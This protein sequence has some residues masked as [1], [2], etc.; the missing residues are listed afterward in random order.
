MQDG[1]GNASGK[2][3]FAEVMLI[4]YLCKAETFNAYIS[5]S[6]AQGKK[7]YQ[8]LIKLLDG[9]GIIKQANASDLKIESI[10]GSTDRKST[11][12]NSSH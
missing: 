10:F 4:E 8:E 3:V 9:S 1:V 11:R 7:V 6:F 5:P 12:L 2:T